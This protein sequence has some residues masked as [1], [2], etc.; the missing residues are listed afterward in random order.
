MDTT[1]ERLRTLRSERDLKQ[2][3][4]AD[5]TGISRT[6]ISQYETGLMPP[7]EACIRLADF[8]GVQLDWILCRSQDRV[9]VPSDTVAEAVSRMAAASPSCPSTADLTAMCR[10]VSAYY[11]A[12]APAGDVPA[13]VL[14]GFAQA[15]TDACAACVAGDV[16]TVADAAARALL[17]AGELPR[18]C[19][20]MTK[21]E[22]IP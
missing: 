3:D 14:A 11:E 9:A 19:A 1:A 5:A 10:A 4:V 12:G 17:A 2:A 20:A 8:F 13:A 6:S 21:G 7:L 18:L 22:N 15:F 16:G